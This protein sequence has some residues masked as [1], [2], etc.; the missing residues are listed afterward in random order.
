M[1]IT[2]A[3]P[4][5][6][7]TGGGSGIGR[8]IALALARRGVN[9]ALVGRRPAPLATV[10]AEGGALGVRA[11]ALPA[12]LADPTARSTLLDRAHA[13]LGPPT[14]LV[15]AA[16]TLAGGDL[17]DLDADTIERALG[18][19]LAA[20]LA[21]T[22]A[23]LPELLAARGAIIL[24]AS[25]AAD[26]PFPSA[27]LYSATKAGVAAFGEALRHEVGPQGVRV[28][29]AYPPAT[30]TAMTHGMARATGF[31][32]HHLADPDAVGEAIVAALVAGR[33]SWHGSVG[34]R[35]LALRP[36]PRPEPHPPAPALAAGA[37]APDADRPGPLW[38]GGGAMSTL[39]RALSRLAVG[40]TALYALDRIAKL[41][42]LAA[43]LRRPAPPAP[44]LWPPVTVLHPIT[45]TLNEYAPLASNLAACARLDYPAPRRHLLLCDAG[46]AASLA[47]C[48]A[49]LAAHPALDAAIIPVPHT[50][51]PIAPKIVKLAAGLAYRAPDTADAVLCFIDD[52][53]A[54]RHAA[55]RDLVAALCAPGEPVGAALGLPCYTNW[56]PPWSALLSGFSNANFP[57]SSAALAF[58]APPSRITGHLVAYRWDLFVRAG[59]LDGLADQID[60]DFAF[61]RRLRAI[62]ATIRQTPVVYD[63]DN[64]LASAPILARQ[65]RRWFVLP[66]QAMARALTLREA[67]TGLLV[68]VGLLLPPLVALVAALARTRAALIA[69]AS[70]LALFTAAA[71]AS[72]HL[73]RNPSPLPR[74]HWWTGPVVALALPLGALAATLLAGNDIEW[75]GQHLRIA[76]GGRFERLS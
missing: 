55:L 44:A 10:A 71:R 24:V 8:G 76:P 67:A 70:C 57:L 74:R 69:F 13:A 26:V 45:C 41:G 49:F 54:P 65:L 42:A 20:P 11:V 19:N 62:G 43:L 32:G 47:T 36:S 64:D 17:A 56:R 28:L 66:R 31:P 34:D 5:A 18:V 29:V 22:R 9:L 58:I 35:A 46:D 30:A 61:A 53:V 7:V 48:R 15:H 38:V 27:T 40:L 75:R 37:L 33:R 4:L 60:D 2:R 3:Y 23:A 39:R 50:D 59:G 1:T 25:L 14:I 63:V 6:L 21:L 12:D 72:E 68:S 52:D 51:G 16:G 73:L